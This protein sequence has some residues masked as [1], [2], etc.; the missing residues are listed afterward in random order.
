MSEL[1]GR[2]VLLTVN[3]EEQMMMVKSSVSSSKYMDA[4]VA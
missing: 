1:G 2:F 3:I 4:S